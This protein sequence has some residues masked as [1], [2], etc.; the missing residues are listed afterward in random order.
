VCLDFSAPHGHLLHARSNWLG[1]DGFVKPASARA[2]SPPDDDTPK[3]HWLPKTR[4]LKI[5]YLTVLALAA[6]GAP[7]QPAPHSAL[8]Q[9]LEFSAAKRSAALGRAMELPDWASRLPARMSAGS[10]PKQA[11]TNWRT[12]SKPAR[13]PAGFQPRRSAARGPLK[14]CALG[15]LPQGRE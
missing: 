8:A 12:W 10:T 11:L 7:P 3:A 15:A 1:Q 2:R 6:H 13:T 5:R 9:E 4:C 14:W